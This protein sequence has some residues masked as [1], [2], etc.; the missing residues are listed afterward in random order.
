MSQVVF[1]TDG[2]FPHSVGGMQ[3]HSR[4]LIE[5]LANYDEIELIVIHPHSFSVFNN[6]KI[7]EISIEGIG[8][9]HFYLYE[10]YLYSKR[11][12]E[13]INRY[14]GAIL[15]SQGLSIWY[16]ISKFKNR[17]IINPHGLEAFQIIGMKEKLKAIP[18]R[19]IFTYL[20]SNSRVIISLGGKLTEILSNII[21]IKKSHISIIPNAVIVPKFLAGFHSNKSSEVED[22]KINVL[23]IGRFAYNK[24]IN[25]LIDVIDQLNL[26]NPNN[27]FIFTLGGKGPLY[28]YY[29]T[30]TK[31]I[32]NIKL[33]GFV[34]DAELETLYQSNDLFVLP[35]LYEGMPT[36]VLEA[37]SYGLPIIVSDVGATK[38]QVDE[39]NGRIIRPGSRKDL[40]DAL[41]WF[42]SLTFEQKK[43]LGNKSKERLNQN[44]T[45]TKVA[46]LHYDLFEKVFIKLKNG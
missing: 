27:K 26:L 12:Y 45:W 23:F 4:L 17:T 36:V 33:L 44:F 9:S 20:F 19:L 8:N 30:R 42:E 2:I 13:V 31:A 39:D 25:I 41:L 35:T 5:E 11:V 16:K 37:M 6:K 29:L 22:S 3:R 7:K 46:K 40:L 18:Y 32:S 34:A 43:L 1:C 10:C 21:N 38:E 24:G 15:Y 28:D 14:P